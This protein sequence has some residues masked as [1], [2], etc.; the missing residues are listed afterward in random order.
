MAKDK[1]HTTPEI[2]ISLQEIYAAER[3]RFLLPARPLALDDALR[4]P[5]L[6][7]IRDRL[8]NHPYRYLDRAGGRHESDLSEYFIREAQF[9]TDENSAWWCGGRTYTTRLSLPLAQMPRSLDDVFAAEQAL[10]GRQPESMGREWRTDPIDPEYAES[11]TEFFPRWEAYAIELLEVS[12]VVTSAPA[13]PTT[14]PA[15]LP[16]R[17]STKQ[18][19][20][21]VIERRKDVGEPSV[22]RGAALARDVE[23]ELADRARREGRKPPALAYIA[24]IISDLGL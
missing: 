17:L 12:A 13:P 16:N 10:G 7:V 1:T 9:N 23:K 21:E 20:V 6:Q 15:P 8:L 11:D 2:W 4:D 24:N 18:M 5:A 3:A 22:L 14:A 19:V